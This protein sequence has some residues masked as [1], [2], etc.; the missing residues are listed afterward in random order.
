M[1]A[2]T[3]LDSVIES[4]EKQRARNR[5]VKLQDFLPAHQTAESSAILT[6]LIRVD[7]E[8]SWEEKQPK[9]LDQYLQEFPSLRRD[10]SALNAIAF[11][12]YRQRQRAG[13]NPSAAEYHRLYRISTREWPVSPTASGFD[14]HTLK[15]P[16]TE[17]G[18]AQA[19]FSGQEMPAIGTEILD[20]ALESELGQGTF[21]KVYLARQKS[22]S[23]RQVAL[24]LTSRKLQEPQTL[25]KLRHTNIM[26]IYSVHETRTWQAICMPYLGKVTLSDVQKTM[27]QRPMP[28]DSTVWTK[29]L[30]ENSP[31]S[32]AW[33][34]LTHSD[35]VL[36]LAEKIAGGLAH[37]HANDIVHRDI[38]PA[39]ILLSFDG[40]PLLL[41]FNLAVHL[42]EQGTLSSMAGTLPYLAPEQLTALVKGKGTTG[43]KQADVYALGLILYEL[44]SGKPA[45]PHFDEKNLLEYLTQLA[46]QRQ[47]AP[48][49]LLESG[50]AISPATA[51]I[52]SRCL[53]IDPAN[54]YAD[55]AQ[56]HT[57]LQRQLQHQ[58]LKYAPD[59][60]IPERIFKWRQRNPGMM[61][62]GILFLFLMLTLFAG[63]LGYRRWQSDQ[64][65]MFQTSFADA[66][67][68][69][70]QADRIATSVWPTQLGPTA[71]SLDAALQ[72]NWNKTFLTPFQQNKLPQLMV[73][74]RLLQSKLYQLQSVRAENE[75]EKLAFHEKALQANSKAVP[76]CDNTG[77]SSL[78]E[79]QRRLLEQGPTQAVMQ[80]LQQIPIDSLHSRELGLLA[81]F[82]LDQG[83]WNDAQ[84]LV[85]LLIERE[86]GW[87]GAWFLSGL[88]HARGGQLQDALHGFETAL[89][90]D[91]A[92]A[93]TWHYR[94]KVRLQLQQYPQAL[95][96]LKHA[97][98]L[99]AASAEVLPDMTLT[100][101]NL[102]D[103][104]A[105]IKTL[106]EVLSDNPD[107]QRLWFLKADLKRQQGDV[108][109]AEADRRKGFQLPS[110]NEVEHVVRGVALREEG[111][112]DEALKAFREAETIAPFYLPAY[113]NQSEIL[114]E[115]RQQPAA[116][117][118]V[119]TR[120]I[121]HIPESSL[122]YASRAVYHARLGQRNPAIQDVQQALALEAAPKPLTLYQ[123]GC[124]YALTSK[125][126]ASD[127]FTALA[128]LT[129]ALEKQFGKEYLNSD[130]DLNLIRSRHDF[131]HLQ[132]RYAK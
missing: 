60:S 92:D 55:A 28:H 86:P 64:R 6:E 35:I 97:L 114:G 47:H 129:L 39:N 40:E 99:G 67:Q 25:A 95:A 106:D 3:A 79:W 80:F 96:D 54:R 105:A 33:K 72:T 38:K 27:Q 41:D 131:Q 23:D 119:L 108:K 21:G 2:V 117:V 110:R 75:S 44:F 113:E 49:S 61:R 121:K 16:S 52:I 32:D 73:H 130:P 89:A 124:V 22:L 83:Q 84:K 91:P 101:W 76:W 18:S 102:Q 29:F 63:Y 111:K 69:L 9:S 51:S 24:K 68:Q 127:A 98:F 14:Q 74:G 57:D 87:S 90:L 118:E 125:V 126:E 59:R 12:E 103:L 70:Q 93:V 45:Y 42:D 34:Q 37:A 77:L 112:F 62:R 88:L 30:D 100:Y 8:Y 19:G 1:M 104:P 122:L 36:L 48:P 11:E 5:N 7:L 65:L 115:Q 116:A 10:E 82:Q 85:Q 53:A 4:F 58:V 13:E 128:Y 50:L 132:K 20:F 66:E 26:P 71:T 123:I 94:G 31:A 56:L 109:G 81:S 78:V 17:F 107:Q 15:Q 43:T 120:A 46:R